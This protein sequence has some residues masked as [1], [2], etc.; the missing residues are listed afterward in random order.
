MKKVFFVGMVL[1]CALTILL[2]SCEEHVPSFGKIG[3]QFVLGNAS[4]NVPEGNTRSLDAKPESET[5]VV[6]LEGGLYM[7]ATLSAGSS[8]DTRATSP[9]AVNTRLRIDAYSGIAPATVATTPV[10]S[11]D[12]TVGAGN[13]LIGDDFTFDSPPG[14]FTFVAYSYNIT[15]V[16]PDAATSAVITNIDP[17]IDFLWGITE[18][19]SLDPNSNHQVG[20]I[21]HHQF[22]QIQITVSTQ[23]F[24]TPP[25]ISGIGTITVIPNNKVDATVNSGMSPTPSSTVAIVTGS[26]AAA[27]PFTWDYT[28]PT[29]PVS[30]K[31]TVYTAGVNPFQIKFGAITL[32]DGATSNTYNNLSANFNMSLLR[33]RSYS[34]TVSFMKDLPEIIVTAPV[35]N[36]YVGAFWRASEIGERIIRITGLNGANLGPWTAVVAEYDKRKSDLWDP[37]GGDGVVLAIVDK[38]DTRISSVNSDTAGDAESFPVNGANI[39]YGNANSTDDYIL[40]RIGLQKTGVT[41]AGKSRSSVWDYT[42]TPTYTGTS[43]PARYA[44]VYLYYGTPVKLFKFYLRQGE[45]ADYVMRDGDLNGSGI[46][47]ADNRSFARRFSPY[48]LKDPSNGTPSTLTTTAVPQYDTGLP[49]GGGQFTE[50]PTQAG[51]FL[52]WNYSRQPFASYT[53]TGIISG[54]TGTQYGSEALWNASHIETCPS[55]YR[56]P[57][58]GNPASHNS[59]GPIA[60]S[61]FRQ[62][63]FLNPHPAQ[64]SDD[65]NYVNTRWGYYADGFFDR[66]LRVNGASGGN[67]GTGSSVS[68]GDEQIAHAGLLFTNP[69]SNASLFFPAAGNRRAND[70]MLYYSG[71]FGD[72]WSSSSSS[73]ASIQRAWSLHIFRN[74][75]EMD[76]AARTNGFSIRCVRPS[77]P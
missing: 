27:V 22:S 5:V 23:G 13:N 59:G 35:T 33:G 56:R 34:L 30:D 75:A 7:Q 66:R 16:S 6:A 29:S 76:E 77:S 71:Y 17:S 50:Y 54:W 1:L 46:A 14:D 45:G 24:A 20:I 3:I 61:E 11:V 25:A 36:P 2:S 37:A 70:G 63:L 64:N 67:P 60:G 52:R 43:F 53:P 49:V 68:T 8:A 55:N 62:S 10:K 19:A 65:I 39:I 12:Y 44:V 42:D 28:V 47:V 72:Y 9:L 41:V 51:H 57:Q 18:K 38:S 15:T 32:N 58:D 26:N 31:Q 40:F 74:F 4:Y 21:M 73:M 69:Y 48:N